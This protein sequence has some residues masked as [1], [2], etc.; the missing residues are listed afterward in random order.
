M[1]FIYDD[2]VDGDVGGCHLWHSMFGVC[3]IL[4]FGFLG[5]LKVLGFGCFRSLNL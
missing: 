1:K 4:I 3:Y 5:V 2:V